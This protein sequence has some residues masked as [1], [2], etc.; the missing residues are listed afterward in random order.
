MCIRDR[1]NGDLLAIKVVHWL[2]RRQPGSRPFFLWTHFIDPHHPYHHLPGTTDYGRRPAD[3]YDS[4]ISFVDSQVNA[5]LLA[6][7]RSGLDDSTIVAL[8]A[9]HGD[10]FKEHG[11]YYHSVS[12]TH[13]RAHET[14]EHL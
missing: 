6:L 8:A 1:Y 10:E 4:E 11:N 12:Y 9:D 2:E 3:R 7:Q 13:L 5:I 14:P